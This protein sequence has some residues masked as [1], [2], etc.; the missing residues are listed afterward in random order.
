MCCLN[1]A[2]LAATWFIRW[3]LFYIKHLVQV[4]A[5]VCFATGA[6][7]RNHSTNENIV[8]WWN[9]AVVRRF[10]F[11]KW[12]KLDVKCVTV[13][14]FISKKGSVQPQHL[15]QLIYRWETK[16]A[17]FLC[18]VDLLHFCSYTLCT[19]NRPTILKY[20]LTVLIRLCLCIA[21]YIC[22]SV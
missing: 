2:N 8:Y 4:C 18:S 3:L 17:Q 7:E 21:V 20:C 12:I 16:N 6:V 22:I 11:K 15:R 5:C 10:T 14:V 1:S 9:T 19:S 13:S